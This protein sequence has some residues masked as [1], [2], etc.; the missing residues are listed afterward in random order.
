MTEQEL[1]DLAY[2]EAQEIP[3]P[4]PAETWRS[5]AVIYVLT[6]STFDLGS[7]FNERWEKRANEELNRHPS[8]RE[9]NRITWEVFPGACLSDLT[10]QLRRL[11]LFYKQT[12]NGPEES[13]CVLCYQHN[14]LFGPGLVKLRYDPPFE[15]SY[16]EKL[17]ALRETLKKFGGVVLYLGVDNTALWGYPG[18][19][20]IKRL[21]EL[22]KEVLTDGTNFMVFYCDEF[23]SRAARKREG[24]WHLLRTEHNIHH[25]SM[26][27]AEAVRNATD[28]LYL[29]NMNFPE[30]ARNPVHV[31]VKDE[32]VVNGGRYDLK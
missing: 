22:S 30:K 31:A 21:I 11:D 16:R 3:P 7:W 25:V 2:F 4:P 20:E 8:G 9:K 14:D 15:R 5:C 12:G 23:C 32:N 13:A 18:D 26:T 17:V 1:D 24:S 28:I 6:D 27:L 29:S 19:R 10:T